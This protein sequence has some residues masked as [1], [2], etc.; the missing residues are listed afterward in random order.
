MLLNAS[1]LKKPKFMLY[2]TELSLLGYFAIPKKIYIH[3]IP[4]IQAILTQSQEDI[5]FWDMT[6]NKKAE[7]L[8]HFKLLPAMYEVDHFPASLLTFGSDSSLPT[9]WSAFLLTAIHKRH[10]ASTSEESSVLT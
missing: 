4:E 3:Q 7:L 8:Y 10:H 6:V 9:F 1:K 2:V 5:F